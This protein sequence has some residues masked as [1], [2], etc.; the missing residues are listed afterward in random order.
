MCSKILQHGLVAANPL[1]G[2]VGAIAPGFTKKVNQGG[3]LNAVAP[4]LG[5]K[6]KGIGGTLGW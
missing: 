2:V 6:L 5:N 3:V 1:G 4:G